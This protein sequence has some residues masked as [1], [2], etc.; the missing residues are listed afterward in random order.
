VSGISANNVAGYFF[1][2]YP[3]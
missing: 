1:Y 3:L 2:P